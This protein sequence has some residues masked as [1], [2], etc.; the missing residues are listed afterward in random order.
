MADDLDALV[1]RMHQG[2]ILYQEAV[3]EFQK[4]FIASALREHRGNVSKTAPSLGLHR[5][6]LSRIALR[7]GLKVS[8]FR[9]PKRRPPGSV[10][11]SAPRKMSQP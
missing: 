1:K 11:L 8:S 7:L 5:N 9:S 4:A 10:G 3:R 2:G 6:S